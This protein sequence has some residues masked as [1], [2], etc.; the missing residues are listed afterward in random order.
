MKLE[1]DRKERSRSMSSSI[2]P[3]KEEWSEK[4]G[5]FPSGYSEKR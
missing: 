2:I 5:F 3:G 1:L 4:F